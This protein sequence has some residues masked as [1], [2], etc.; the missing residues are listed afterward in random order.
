MHTY[1]L[2]FS[3]RCVNNGI[4]VLTEFRQFNLPQFIMVVFTAAEFHYWMQGASLPVPPL[5]TVVLIRSEWERREVLEGLPVSPFPTKLSDRKP[6]W[7]R[8]IGAEL[9]V[10]HV[11]LAH[12]DHVN[13]SWW[14]NFGGKPQNGNTPATGLFALANPSS[15]WPQVLSRSSTGAPQPTLPPAVA[16]EVENFAVA[17]YRPVMRSGAENDAPRVRME[18]VAEVAEVAEL[19]PSSFALLTIENEPGERPFPLACCLVELPSSF[20]AGFDPADPLAEVPVLWW[21]P[22]ESQKYSGMWTPW[23]DERG[24][25]QT[26]GTF[27]RAALAVLNV[28][29][30]NG[31]Y[32][33]RRR[34]LRTRT[35]Y[36]TAESIRMAPDSD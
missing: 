5:P 25:E 27:P 12:D 30:K 17:P 36:M 3:R 14:N 15:L 18:A 10:F 9:R 29:L 11:D 20:P 6:G 21:K 2:L 23:L 7:E 13:H 19:V 34:G 16:E 1:A 31:G 32:N 24:R 26:H 22:D 33:R 28:Q 35:V 4:E 8:A